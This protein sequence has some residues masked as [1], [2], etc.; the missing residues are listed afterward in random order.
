LTSL[1]NPY[2]VL[3][4]G[5]MLRDEEPRSV[6]SLLADMNRNTASTLQ[7]LDKIVSE[8]CSRQLQV[9]TIKLV[10]NMNRNIQILSNIR[11]RMGYNIEEMGLVSRATNVIPFMPWYA[12]VG[13]DMHPRCP[14]SAGSPMLPHQQYV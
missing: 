8:G 13:P 4:I 14:A 6:D 5:G 1:P 3:T 9:D 12:Y 7:L 10:A 11:V 2:D